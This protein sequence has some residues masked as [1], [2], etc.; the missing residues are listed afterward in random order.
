M[1]KMEKDAKSEE[2]M[3]ISSN[4]LTVNVRSATGLGVL[5]LSFGVSIA[6]V[7]TS[8]QLDPKRTVSWIRV[9]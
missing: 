8:S 7:L 9:P 1:N 4:N 6:L 3:S 5:R 2:S